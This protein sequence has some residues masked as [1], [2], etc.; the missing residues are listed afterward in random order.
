MNHSHLAKR[1][2]AVAL[3]AVLST[4]VL[5]AAA[6]PN[7]D[8]TAHLSPDISI[9]VDGSY[10][11]F[12]SALGNE[13]HPFLYNGTTYLPIRA[14]GELMGK[15]VTWDQANQT[16]SL[17]GVNSSGPAEGTPDLN[18]KP[19]PIDAKVRPEVTITVDGTEQ[20]FTDS[21]GNV[22][23]PMS[24]SGSVYLPVR[25]IG[26]L[27]KKEVEWNSDTRTVSL[28]SP[29][30]NLIS[31]ETAKAIALKHAGLQ[32]SQVTFLYAHLEW[33]DGV[34]V[35]DVEFYTKD[36]KEYD[37]EIDAHTGTILSFDYDAEHNPPSTNPGS[38][39]S[40]E[41]AT[42]I[43]LAQVPGATNQNISKVELDR[44][45]GRMEYEV[46]II[47]GLLKYEFEIDASTGAIL[48][49]DTESIY[50]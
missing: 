13:T 44:D 48:S 14:I 35:Y 30:T 15:N 50:D 40:Q 25:N 7:K 21:N 49:K 16:V 31:P 42:R 24:Y 39:I 45:N 6:T 19:H 36:F 27:M 37:Y 10:R 11:N 9:V 29:A 5:T 1:A 26:V 20:T 47:Y 32:S 3:C 4:S 38:Y 41:E 12:Y 17:S 46:E 2:G 22:I 34:Q 23:H 28:G 8:V 33:E 43:A 18:A